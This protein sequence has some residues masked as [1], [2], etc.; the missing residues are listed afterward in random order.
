MRVVFVSWIKEFRQFVRDKVL[1]PMVFLAPLFIVAITPLAYEG[2]SCFRVAIV[3]LERTMES[4]QRF[5]V[6]SNSDQFESVSFFSTID[7]AKNEMDRGELDLIVVIR[8]DESLAFLEGSAGGRSLI[9]LITLEKLLDEEK[10]IEP[11]SFHFLF[12][13][14]GGY[15]DYITLTM[16]ILMVTIIGSSLI[17]LGVV[18]E[19]EYGLEEQLAAAKVPLLPY[20]FGKYLFHLCLALVV[21]LVLALFIALFYG[22]CCQGEFLPTFIHSVV[23]L[24]T[25]GGMGLLV[26]SFAPTQ[27][28]V[29]YLQTLVLI[30][31]VMLST[32][33]SQLSSMPSWA[34]NLRFINPI[35]YG[36]EGY[37]KLYFRG[38]SL[39]HI[40]ELLLGL[41]LLGVALHTL[42][43]LR[44]K[45]RRG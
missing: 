44:F 15:A 4:E 32:M 28:R 11:F 10:L 5:K 2:N 17:M 34:A 45:K 30:I 23:Y 36:I 24:S 7:E 31:L 35:Y 37:R 20:F 14:G 40:R 3:D 18:K 42:A 13:R 12:N 6:L 39:Y 27:T 25:L 1:V 19:R 26:A 33:F 16:M 41:A 38:A 9:A 8:K 29:I 43:Y 21:L 22:L